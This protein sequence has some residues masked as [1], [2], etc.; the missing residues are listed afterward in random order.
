MYSLLGWIF[1]FGLGFA[2]GTVFPQTWPDSLRIAL[3][4]MACVLW[5]LFWLVIRALLMG[6]GIDG[7]EF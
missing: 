5:S 7:R 2:L 1:Q 3:A 4:A 6:R